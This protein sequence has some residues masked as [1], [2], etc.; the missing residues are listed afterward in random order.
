[1]EGMP[2]QFTDLKG[3]MNYIGIGLIALTILA[4][5]YQIYYTHT[6]IAADIE[7]DKTTD[8]TIAALSKKVDNLQNQLVQKGI[9]TA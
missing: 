7:R 2:S 1:M 4:L 6:Q 5:G 9:V 8:A 3:N